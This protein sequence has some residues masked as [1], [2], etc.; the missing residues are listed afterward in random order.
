[1]YK[2]IY[3]LYQKNNKDLNINNK[4]ENGKKNENMEKQKKYKEKHFN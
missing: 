2:D 4:I 1:M 3:E